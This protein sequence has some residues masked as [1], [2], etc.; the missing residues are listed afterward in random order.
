MSN[1]IQNPFKILSV[2]CFLFS[3]TQIGFNEKYGIELLFFGWSLD[4][5]FTSFANFVGLLICF[6]FFLLLK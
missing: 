3:L 1:V 2:I 4:L 6:S 5:L